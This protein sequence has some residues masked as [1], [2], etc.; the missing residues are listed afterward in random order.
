[1]NEDKPIKLNKA[2]ERNLIELGLYAFA[3]LIKDEL[4][5]IRF[6]QEQGIN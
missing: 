1:M 3:D 6:K 2:E 5:E 4:E